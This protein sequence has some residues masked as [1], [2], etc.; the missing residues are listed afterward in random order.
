VSGCTGKELP[1][2]LHLLVAAVGLAFGAGGAH[3]ANLNHHYDFST[4]VVDLA[5]TINGTLLGNANVAGGTLNLDGSGDW[6]E[7]PTS[8]VPNAGSWSVALFAKGN[9]VQA[10]FAELISQGATGGPGFYIG[11]DSS[12]SFIRATDS[13]AST[14]VAF[15]APNVWT[16]YALVVDAG[17]NTSQLFVGG[18]LAA[19]VPYAIATSLNGSPTRLG[20]QF[21]PFG[22]FFNGSIDDVRTYDGVLTPLEVAQLANPVPE[23]ASAALLA[24]GGA[25]LAAVARR[26]RPR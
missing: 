7:F 23:P 19:M 22:E 6:A 24:L 12:G 14:G 16:H 21:D 11:T 26:R 3:A 17:A 15:G 1:M 2:N 25:A 13:W 10:G 9:G 8:I 20:R 18:T 5:G 4:G